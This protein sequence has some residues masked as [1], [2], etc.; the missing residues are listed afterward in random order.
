MADD[1]KKQVRSCAIFMSVFSVHEQVTYARSRGARSHLILLGRPDER[2]VPDFLASKMARVV[3]VSGPPDEGALADVPDG[4]DICGL[5]SIFPHGGAAIG[6][7][8]QRDDAPLRIRIYLEGDAYSAVAQSLRPGKAQI[9]FDIDPLADGIA[10]FDR[11][12][13]SCNLVLPVLS[14]EVQA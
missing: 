8:V 14:F 12:D 13:F 3:F 2:W 10:S 5:L 1:S 6:H 11:L 4:V 9:R 7:G